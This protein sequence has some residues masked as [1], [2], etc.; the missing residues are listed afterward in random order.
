VRVAY[1][2]EQCWHRVPGGTAVA[3][4]R[5]ARELAAMGVDLA[6]VRA[7]HLRAP[8]PGYEPS[9]PTRA[10]PVPGPLLYDAWARLGRPSVQRATGPVD[11]I[12]ATTLLAPPRSAPLVVTIHDVAFVH[13]PTQFTRRGTRLFHQSLRRVAAEADL[14]LASSEATARDCRAVGIREERLRIVR[15]GVDVVPAPPTD[16]SATRHRYGLTEPYLLFAGT[17]EPRKNLVS[18]LRAF[19]RLDTEHLLVLVGPSGWGHQPR[20]AR[21]ERVRLLGFVPERDLRALY[22]GADAF[23]YP[24]IREGF[25]LPV[26][27]AMAQG[28]PVVTSLGTATEE[29]AGDAAELVDPEDP[30]SIAAGIE[31]ALERR[32]VLSELGPKRAAAFPW[33]TTAEL[34]L[35]AYRSVLA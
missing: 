29:V 18:L 16:V 32:E 10:L 20:P 6:G 27:E 9:V 3:A 15:L 14:I 4:L 17:F 13:E 31:R 25:G 7:A 8:A 22:A 12:H 28:A 21:N 24:S 23:C 2:L 1:T 11:L 19:D 5:V 33:H 30:A 26:L 34:T 35:D